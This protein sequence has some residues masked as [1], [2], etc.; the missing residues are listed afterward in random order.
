MEQA[1]TVSIWPE[2]TVG[3]LWREVQG[4]YDE[5][6]DCVE[7]A[8]LT[9]PVDFRSRNSQPAVMW[10]RM[11]ALGPWVD[12]TTREASLNALSLESGEDLRL[13]HDVKVGWKSNKGH[14]SET[15]HASAV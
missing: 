9:A 13:T 8:R 5:H 14:A 11:Y 6:K 10:V 7:Y 1:R 12:A 3:R 4:I 2:N 15:R